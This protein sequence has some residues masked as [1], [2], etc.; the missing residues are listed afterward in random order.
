MDMANFIIK[1]VNLHMKA[2]GTKINSMEEV[3]YTMINVNK[4]PRKVLILGT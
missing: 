2:N 1:L 3:Q 4:F